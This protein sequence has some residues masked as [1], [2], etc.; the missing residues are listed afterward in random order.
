MSQ[1]SC[2]S[3]ELL[4]SLVE[5][6]H[7]LNTSIENNCT[8]RRYLKEHELNIILEESLRDESLTE[9]EMS[10]LS[11]ELSVLFLNVELQKAIRILVDSNN[12]RAFYD[13]EK[14]TYDKPDVIVSE[15]TYDFK[16]TI[17]GFVFGIVI[18]TLLFYLLYFV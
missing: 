11:S 1:E 8:D 15:K 5:I 18:A 14:S 6:E 10:A 16:S 9:S 7:K 4:L 3:R 13:F 2:N 12:F 17:L